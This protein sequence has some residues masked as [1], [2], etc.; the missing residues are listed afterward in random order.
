MKTIHIRIAAAIAVI[1][2]VIL[3]TWCSGYNFDTRNVNVAVNVVLAIVFAGL[4][5]AAPWDDMLP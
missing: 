4:A 3:V 5:F 1:A 2:T